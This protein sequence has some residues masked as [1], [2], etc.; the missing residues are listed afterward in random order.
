MAEL[1]KICD[2][3]GRARGSGFVADDRGTVVTSHEA[4]E[5]LTRVVLH[6]PG[7][8]GRTWLAEAADVTALPGLALALVRTDGLGM[9][10]LPV[11]LREVIEP[12]TYVR[13]PARGW[14]QARVLGGAEVTYPATDRFHPVPAGVAVELA[15]GTDG[16]DALR[17]GGEACGGP[18][19]DAGTGAVLA[20]LGTALRAAAGADPDGPLAAL[21]ERNAA[22]VPGHGADLNLAGALEL[23]A[24]TLGASIPPEGPQPVERPGTAAE[25]A[26]FTEGDRP[27]L[28]LV[29]EPGTGRTTALA[30][31]AVRRARGARPAPTLWLRGADLRAGDTSLADAATRALVT[32]ARIV[33]TSTAPT[34]PGPWPDG[35]GAGTAAATDRGTGVGDCG[36]DDQRGVPGAGA[37]G[38]RAGTEAA[39]EGRQPGTARDPDAGTDRDTGIGASA[40]DSQRT[41]PDRGPAGPRAGA[42]A[43]DSEQQPGTGRD[44]D[45]ATD[46]DTGIGGSEVH[47]QGTAPGTWTGGR[48][49]GAAAGDSEQQPGTGRDPDAGNDR[50]SGIGGSGVRPQSTAPGAWT[51]HGTGP[52]HGPGVGIVPGPGGGTGLGHGAEPGHGT[53]TG[54]G[55]GPAAGTHGTGPGFGIGI[56]ADGIAEQVARL[57]AGAGRGLLVVLDAPE[58]MP[59][60]LTHRLGPWTEATAG[61]LRATGARLV[62]AARPEYWERAGALYPPG[63]LHSPARPARRLPPAL[64]LADL[65]AAEAEAA[66]ARLGIPADAVREADARHPLTLRLLA[67]IRAAEVTAGRPGRDEVF[68]A[69]LDLLCLRAAVRIAAACADAGGVKVHGPGVRRLAARVAGRVHEAARRCLGP[70][71]GQVDRASFEELFPWR[72]GWASAVLT[73]GLLVPAGPGY[74]F[75]HEELS[76]WIQAGHL[77]VPTALGLLVHGPAGPG[78]PV[79]RHRIGPVL[80]ALRR[81]APDQLRTELTGL[82]HRLNRLAEEPERATRDSAWWA[83][84]LLRET[85]LRA[86]DA[87]PHLPVLHALAEHVTR[88]GPGEF[89]GWFWTRLR[90]PEPDRL[91]LLRR[92]LPADPA[93]AVPGDRYL[94]AAA[95]R[96]ARDPQRAQ[97]L[98]CAWFGDGRRLRGRPGATVATA[99]Q[100]LLH[101]HRSL[102]VD[103]LTEALVTAAHPRADELLAVLAEEEPSA[104]C[105]AVDRWA[106]DERPGRRVAA[107]AYG[108][109]TAPHART[110]ADRELLR[111]AAQALLARPADSTLHGSALAIL[112]R[113]PQVRGRYLPDALTCFRDPELGSRLPAAAL[114]A[115][116]PV[117]PDPDEVFAALRARADGEVVR[118]LATLTTPGLARRAADL[119]REHLARCPADAPHAAFFVDRRLDQGPAAASVVRPLVLDLLRSAPAGVRAELAAVLAAPGGETSYPLRGDL[120]DTLLREEADPNVLDAFL[121]TLAAKAA[122]RPEDRTREL[123]R[124]TGRQLLRTP[125]GPAVFERRTVELARA[126]P[127]FGALV[128][129]WLA[130]AA[131]EAAALLGPSARRTVETL[132][133]AAPD[134]T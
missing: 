42:A 113:D 5:G 107:A 58:E 134:V 1:V 72:T 25:L 56:H 21:L 43:G 53:G 4:V 100:A 45:A 126:E 3:A 74:R 78:L 7:P 68:A 57:A 61:W 87:R 116:L 92:L 105:R 63:A 29:G 115:A 97:P 20:V 104:L 128:A 81:L 103:D 133:R 12:G 15:I 39:G 8:A 52:H 118:A 19:L 69:H 76:D 35:L 102:A 90:L 37:G 22:T 28:G 40:I 36:I 109:A 73:E 46:R 50:G 23:T 30:A 85:L 70:G 60:E 127:A 65:T 34:P 123:L 66:R 9:R 130:T 89:G 26:A 98:L 64:P 82:V 129:R 106:H 16:R 59:P 88:A 55:A 120:A 10:P 33:S 32:A 6:A 83:A 112:L 41:G 124:R 62:V 96:L 91:D 14:R 71:Q 121:G 131:A 101:T 47:P 132:G 93:E 31:L 86:P 117:L 119:V 13:L 44:L 67:G 11:A 114:V 111:Y 95:R 48:G 125:G 24:T 38:R 2:P 75:A 94:D 122:G 110:P 54:S 51:G 80:E 17:W 108:L 99:A 49:A 18:V 27:V 77:D 84:R 79:P